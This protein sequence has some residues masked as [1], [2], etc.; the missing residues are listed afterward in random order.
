M[1]NERDQTYIYSHLFTGGIRCRLDNIWVAEFLDVEDPWDVT[2]WSSLEESLRFIMKL[3][4]TIK[5]EFFELKAGKW[6]KY[7]KTEVELKTIVGDGKYLLDINGLRWRQITDPSFYVLSNC[8]H[9]VVDGIYCP[10]RNRI[11][12]GMPWMVEAYNTEVKL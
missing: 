11:R 8:H 4:P 9:G 7:D 12:F 10:E 1:N 3:L 5:Q 6:V 2:Y